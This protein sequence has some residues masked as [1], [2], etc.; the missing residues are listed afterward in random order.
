[1]AAIRE[2]GGVKLVD[3]TLST[4]NQD[5]KEVMTG[6]ATARIDP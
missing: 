2:E 6:N 3:L 1:M 5:G 4:T